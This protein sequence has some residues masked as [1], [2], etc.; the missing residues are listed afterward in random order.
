M[1]TPEA[2]REGLCCECVVIQSSAS[3]RQSNRPESRSHEHRAQLAV[4]EDDVKEGSS[5]R[6]CIIKYGSL[7][8]FL[9]L[10]NI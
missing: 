8:D 1:I 2:S 9:L 4:T 7:V 5:I 3:W 10:E 6:C